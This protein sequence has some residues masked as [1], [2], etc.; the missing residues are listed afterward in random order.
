MSGCVH[1]IFGEAS[2]CH[3]TLVLV[4]CTWMEKLIWRSLSIGSGLG[5][6]VVIALCDIK[7][8]GIYIRVGVFWRRDLWAHDSWS[9]SCVLTDESRN[10]IC[11]KC[12]SSRANKAAGLFMRYLLDM[13][14]NAIVNSYS[15]WSSEYVYPRVRARGGTRT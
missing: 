11:Y 10:T 7:R 1:R 2:E 12:R 6:Y 5:I 13:H 15:L 4:I 8:I 9:W 3:W 14:T